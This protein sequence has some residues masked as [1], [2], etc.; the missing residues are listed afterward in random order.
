MILIEL[1]FI[2]TNYDNE[3]GL[4]YREKALAKTNYRGIEQALDWYVLK[5][6]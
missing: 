5:F 6:F 3:N 1:E 4:C 2:Y